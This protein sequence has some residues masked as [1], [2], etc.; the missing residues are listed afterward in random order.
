MEGGSVAAR[1]NK[2][3]QIGIQITG[4][5][6]NLSHN[7]TEEISPIPSLNHGAILGKGF[8]LRFLTDPSIR[9]GVVALGTSMTCELDL[10]NDLPSSLEGK[11]N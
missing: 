8:S 10:G 5:Y 9:F 2:R 7:A 1:Y 4:W 11:R 6:G 3:I